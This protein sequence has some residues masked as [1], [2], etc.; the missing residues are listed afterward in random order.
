[1]IA[2]SLAATAVLWACTSGDA[3]TGQR[4]VI[5]VAIAPEN[6]SVDVGA[7][8]S[9]TATAHLRDGEAKDVSADSHTVWASTDPAVVTE[10]V[11][12]PIYVIGIDGLDEGGLAKEEAYFSEVIELGF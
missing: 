8:L 10:H 9:F 1:M 3:V 12:C 11:G 2:S 5:A 4:D 7:S 6:P